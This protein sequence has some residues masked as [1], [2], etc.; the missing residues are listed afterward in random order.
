MLPYVTVELRQSPQMKRLSCRLRVPPAS[1]AREAK[2]VWQLE[3]SRIVVSA[4]SFHTSPLT[5]AVC[6]ASPSTSRQADL[7]VCI[8]CP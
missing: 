4:A 3:I 8:Y 5:F 7:Y 2:R 6:A 1:G